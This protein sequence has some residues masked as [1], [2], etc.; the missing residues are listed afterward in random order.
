MNIFICALNDWVQ[1]TTVFANIATCLTAA[2]AVS[3]VI[4]FIINRFTK[5][6]F[7]A[8][9]FLTAANITKQ[10]VK[11]IYFNLTFKN[12][13]DKEV[14][15]VGVSIRHKGKECPVFK[16]STDTDDIKPEDL[17]ANL[18]I[19]SHQSATFGGLFFGNKEL[20]SK[21][22]PVELIVETTRKTFTYKKL[23]DFNTAS[24]KK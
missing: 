5:W 16:S 24:T 20:Y 23:I 19:S 14:S 22:L 9:I 10:N 3:A 15:I 12:R 13:T 21:V 18:S 6:T 4:Y 2:S 7:K 8:E 11:A 1:W 17:L